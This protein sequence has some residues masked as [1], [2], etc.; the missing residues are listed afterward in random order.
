S[1]AS[2]IVGRWRARQYP[3]ETVVVICPD[4]G[5]RYVEAVYDHKRLEQNGCL[6]EGVLTDAPA[7]ENHPSTALPPWNRYHWNRRSQEAV[8]HVLENAS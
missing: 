4:E 8:L 1:G 3:E 6:H 2:Y 7:T 5:H